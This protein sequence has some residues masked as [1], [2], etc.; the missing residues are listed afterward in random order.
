MASRESRQTPP[1]A[2]AI[3]LGYGNLGPEFEVAR[4]MVRLR[5]CPS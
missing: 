4:L 3:C 1:A 5:E 2:Q